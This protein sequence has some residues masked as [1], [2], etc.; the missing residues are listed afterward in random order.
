LEATPLQENNM[1]QELA[2][3]IG[4]A[5]VATLAATTVV[6]T[7]TDALADDI[8][9]DTTKFVSTASRDD[10][11]AIVKAEPALVLQAASE[12]ALQDNQAT[13]VK[14]NYTGAQA[15]AAYIIERREV[16]A[17]NAEDSGSNSPWLLKARPADAAT[18]GGP[19]R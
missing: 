9:M 14:S 10:V 8:T 2:S 16:A 11:R 3:A 19:P 4:V 18:M 13:R 7:P 1:N 15:R 17:L 12:W 5:A 6:F